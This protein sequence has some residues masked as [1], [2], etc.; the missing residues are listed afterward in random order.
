M[1]TLNGPLV[2]LALT[3]AHGQSLKPN[4]DPR[5]ANPPPFKGINSRMPFL[6]PIKGQGLIK[7]G[8]GFH[9]NPKP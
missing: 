2:S 9:P 3:E 8:S 1:P 4:V 7:Q 6:V 5:L